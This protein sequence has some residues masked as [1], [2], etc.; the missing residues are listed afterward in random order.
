MRSTHA[1]E[2]QCIIMVAIYL[3]QIF[4]DGVLCDIEPPSKKKKYNTNKILIVN[5]VTGHLSI[6]A[7]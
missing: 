1:A 4:I 7:T 3:N 2:D 5:Q 6:Q